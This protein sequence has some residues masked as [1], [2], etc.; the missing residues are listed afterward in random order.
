MKRIIRQLPLVCLL[1][2]ARAAVAQVS[3]FACEPEWAALAQEIGGKYV[4]TSSATTALQDVHH[5]QARPSLIAKLRQADLLVCTGAGLESGWLPVLQRR[6]NN[7]AVQTGAAGY[8]EATQY[9]RLL[10]R[11]AQVDRAA[12]D[13]HAQGNP[14][15]Q[16]DPRNDPPIA[17]ALAGRL[18]EIDPEHAGD[19]AAGLS[20]F[21]QR[22]ASAMDGWQV[23]AQPLQGVQIVVHHDSW[24]YL[25]DWL[26]LQRVATLEPKPGVPPTSSH[27]SK[28]L[29]QLQQHDATAI[30]RSPYQNAKA[31]DWLSQRT[32]LPIVVLPTTVGGNTEA[33]DLFGLF[34][35]ILQRLLVVTS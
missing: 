25:A 1:L 18:A 14:H 17:Q 23:Q 19:Y 29:Q 21:L 8:L 7:P 33:K 27:L 9:V 22:W 13:V 12:G 34:N 35:D 2:L 20:G 16:L 26:G 28:L 30:I 15:I 10:D 11:P 4:D 5:I 32:G 24:P 31:A 6:A 3:V